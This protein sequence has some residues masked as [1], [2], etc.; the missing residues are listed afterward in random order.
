MSEIISVGQ[1]FGLWG[2]FYRK[3]GIIAHTG[4]GNTGMLLSISETCF[5]HIDALIRIEIDLQSTR[6]QIISGIGGS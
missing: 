6:S 3:I 1:A 4:A 5:G 2:R